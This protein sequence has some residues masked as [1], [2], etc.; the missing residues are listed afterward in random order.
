[1]KF[2]HN[3]WYLAAYSSEIEGPLL[4]RTIAGENILF[5]RRED[6]EV[7]AISN[8]CPHRFAPL[9]RGKREG[10]VVECG[11]HGLRFGPDGQCVHNPFSDH[12]PRSLRV[13]KYSAAE[14]YGMIWVWLGEK[15]AT[16][17]SIPDMSFF[18]GSD[19]KHPGN[20]Y[21]LTNYRYDILV[22][23]L[24]DVSHA[25]YLH[26]GTFSGGVP[27]KSRAES[28]IKGDTVNITWKQ[29]D[30]Q[31]PQFMRAMGAPDQADLSIQIEWSPSQVIK[32]RSYLAPLGGQFS[33]KPASQFFHVPTPCDENHTHYF[34]GVTPLADE[35]AAR[36]AAQFQATV[37]Q[38]EDGPMLEAIDHIMAGRELTDLKPVLLAVDVGPMHARTV[39]K[40]LV[41]AETQEIGQPA[42]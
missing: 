20:S 7:T 32:Y 10:D 42:G 2:L 22:D 33:D 16:L 40:R 30:V 24:L 6:G 3:V 27:P 34:M 18:S 23:N 21:I 9:D 11:Y 13:R 31:M 14:R 5:Y 29:W 15:P 1:M 37:V 39:M 26:H 4:A 28:E 41:A 25:D 36:R 12:I 8:I 38:N 19:G 35:E 17:D